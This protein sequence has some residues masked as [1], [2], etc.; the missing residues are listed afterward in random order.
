MPLVV[1]EGGPHAIP[2]THADQVNAALLDFLRTGTPASQA[3]R[4][5][6][7]EPYTL[8]KRSWRNHQQDAEVLKEAGMSST[9]V[10]SPSRDAAVGTVDM[11]LEVQI[12]PVSDVDRSK[13]FYE[14][15]GWRLD[16][17]VAP[18]DGLPIVQF[19]P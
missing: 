19:T 6:C 14:R 16:D 12:I 2:W 17:D 1:V 11:H 18:L 3:P 4:R 5:P 13:Q 7:A 15:L 9:E 10:H 8:A